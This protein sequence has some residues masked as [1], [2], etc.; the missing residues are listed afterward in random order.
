MDRL[1]LTLCLLFVSIFFL[2]PF[3]VLAGKAA[4]SQSSVPDEKNVVWIGALR[5]DGF[6]VP[7]FRKDKAGWSSP[8]PVPDCDDCGLS[9]ENTGTPATWTN[10]GE[11]IELKWGDQVSKVPKQWKAWSGE[12]KNL[13]VQKIAP[14]QTHCQQVWALKTNARDLSKPDTMIEASHIV[15]GGDL[16][17][18]PMEK[19]DKNK[20][21]WK[22]VAKEAGRFFKTRTAGETLGMLW[23]VNFDPKL[24]HYFFRSEKRGPA[25]PSDP[26][27]WSAEVLQGWL[28]KN[29]N[30]IAA[31]TSIF[32]DPTSYL[33]DCDY[34]NIDSERPYGYVRVD[35]K[36]Y[37]IYESHGYEDSKLNLVEL[38]SNHSAIILT[39]DMGAC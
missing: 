3:S 15:T 24:S 6:I 14:V 10:K 35:N 8:W 38:F 9:P 18:T 17:F 1:Q 27:C 31:T 16:V 21:D 39:F 23:K 2:L 37:F 30:G 34:K 20:T 13:E 36:V 28:T 4:T 22:W 7:L 5:E 12:F 25:S 32:G 33:T 26:S 11:M 29:A 19:V